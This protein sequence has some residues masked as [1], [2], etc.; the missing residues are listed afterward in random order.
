MIDHR[1]VRRLRE[2]RGW[3]K[4]EL[5]R[6][7]GTTRQYIFLMEAGRNTNP[8]ARLVQ[9]LAAALE[10]PVTDLLADVKGGAA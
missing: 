7:A 2:E 9:A 1:A 6:R 4:A 5:A 10:V 3:S 8:S